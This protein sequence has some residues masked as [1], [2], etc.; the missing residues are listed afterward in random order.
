M[1]C[2]CLLRYGFLLELEKKERKAA[3]KQCHFLYQD[4]GVKFDG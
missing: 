1:I 3:S 4:F 2:S